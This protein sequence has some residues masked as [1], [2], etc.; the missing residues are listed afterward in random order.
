MFSGD[1]EQS[2]RK[3][4]V[5]IIK[6]TEKSREQLLTYYLRQLKTNRHQIIDSQKMWKYISQKLDKPTEQCKKMFVKLKRLNQSPTPSNQYK[7]M[8]DEILSTKCNF[9]HPIVVDKKRVDYKNVEVPHDKLEKALEYYFKNL[10]EFVSEKYNKKHAWRQLCESLNEPVYKIYQKINYLK[11]NYDKLQDSSN[12]I[13]LNL[14][15]EKEC[16]ILK[17]DVKITVKR[18]RCKLWSEEEKVKLKELYLSFKD[19]FTN[20]KYSNKYLWYKIGVVLNRGYKEC[21]KEFLLLKAEESMV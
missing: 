7:G 5:K 20:P 3:R 15:L 11:T 12:A 8:I 19:K 18:G 16:E 17:S 13:I 9:I 6:W 4:K 10:E 2:T 21:R 14:I 1:A